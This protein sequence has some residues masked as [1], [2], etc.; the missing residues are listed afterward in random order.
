MNPKLALEVFP[1]DVLQRLGGVV[2]ID[3][4][5]VLTTFDEQTIGTVEILLT[6]WSCPYIDTNALNI[7]P[8]LTAVM[9][10]A[11]SVKPHVD[12]A[13]F[14]RGVTVS[15]A[16]EAN[17]LPVAE[18]TVA[19]LVLAAKQTFTHARL[20]SEGRPRLGIKAGEDAG[21][22]GTSVGIIGASRTGRL[23]MERLAPFGVRILL[24]DPYVDRDTAAQFGAELVSVDDVFRHSDYVSVHAPQLPETRHIVNAERLA[25]LR[26]GGVIVNTA[27]GSLVDTDALADECATGRISAVLDVTDPEPLAAGHRLLAMPNVFVTPHLAGSRGRELRRLGEFAAAEVERFVRGEPLR[28]QVHSADLTRIA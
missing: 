12:P 27:R 19:A 22:S 23:V 25:L 13:V 16:S 2:D 8:R 28:G 15:A 26:V 21:I 6:G 9:H 3:P 20:Y 17:A 10:G 11:G 18:F 4:S 5:V 7:A 1:A 14:D 24:S